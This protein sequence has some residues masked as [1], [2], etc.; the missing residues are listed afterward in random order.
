MN[1]SFTV[2]YYRNSDAT[3]QAWVND[4]RAELVQGHEDIIDS[5]SAVLADDRLI[6]AAEMKNLLNTC[7]VI[8][9]R[10]TYCTKYIFLV[11]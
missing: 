9:K 8:S 6:V 5:E 1:E 3:L 7:D 2:S 4:H 11:R 10:A